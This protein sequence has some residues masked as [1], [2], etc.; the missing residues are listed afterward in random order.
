MCG[1]FQKVD[2]IIAPIVYTLHRDP[3][4]YDSTGVAGVS[5][6][7]TKLRFNGP[8]I[9]LSH[10]VWFRL[11]EAARQVTLLWVETASP[12]DMEIPDDEAPF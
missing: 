7:R 1:G 9:F 4:G 5:L 11:D 12:D 8:E 3:L 2:E 6:A 10:L